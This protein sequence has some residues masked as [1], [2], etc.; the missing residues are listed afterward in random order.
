LCV[1]VCVCVLL[2]VLLCVLFIGEV[3]RGGVLPQDTATLV[4]PCIAYIHTR[5]PPGP[6][7]ACPNNK[8][9]VRRNDKDNATPHHRAQLA[10]T[11]EIRTMSEAYW[12][13]R[14]PVPISGSR[15]S[16]G[17]L[18]GR[19]EIA[20]PNRPFLRG[21]GAAADTL[22]G[23]PHEHNRNTTQHNTIRDETLKGGDG[24]GK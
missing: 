1:A 11:S 20:T 5:T 17:G 4:H 13:F 8:D 22:D 18:R 15:G 16:H 24:R 21:R 23:S 3:L 14:A 7:W 2:C 9:I 10:R 12:L 6:G 19:S